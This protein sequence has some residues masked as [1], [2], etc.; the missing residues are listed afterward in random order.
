VPWGD[1]HSEALQASSENYL[2]KSI[3]QHAILERTSPCA[4]P[5]QQTNTNTLNRL[6]L[7]GNHNCIIVILIVM[8][9]GYILPHANV[10]PGLYGYLHHSKPGAFVC[11][12]VCVCVCVFVALFG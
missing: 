6:G 4:G 12:C 5:I 11:V 2:V 8:L 10:S 7:A 9:C 1:V 3:T